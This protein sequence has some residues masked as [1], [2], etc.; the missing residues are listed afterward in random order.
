MLWLSMLAIAA[1][2]CSA[3]L[4]SAS[5][6][7]ADY[8]RRIAIDKAM[9]QG[10]GLQLPAKSIRQNRIGVSTVF[11][12][13][14]NL[15]LL[16]GELWQSVV[17][18]RMPLKDVP[19]EGIQRVVPLGLYLVSLGGLVRSPKVRWHECQWLM[20]NA[21]PLPT[22]LLMMEGEDNEQV[23]WYQ[24]W[25]GQKIRTVRPPSRE[26]GI[27]LAS[28]NRTDEV[29]ASSPAL[30]PDVSDKFFGDLPSLVEKVPALISHR[31]GALPVHLLLVLGFLAFLAYLPAAM[32]QIYKRLF[33]PQIN[34][35][36]VHGGNF[37]E[38]DKGKVNYWIVPDEGQDQVVLRLTAD[39]STASSFYVC[40]GDRCSEPLRRKATMRLN[41]QQLTM[42]LSRENFGTRS[43][44]K[45]RGFF[46]RTVYV[47]VVDVPKV[48]ITLGTVSKNAVVS[49]QPSAFRG[50]FASERF[51]GA[52]EAVSFDFTADRRF[53]DF[54]LRTSILSTRSSPRRGDPGCKAS[55]ADQITCKIS[56][57]QQWC[58]KACDLSA[59]LSMKFGTE[60]LEKPLRL[61]LEVR[62]SELFHLQEVVDLQ[63]KLDA[64]PE[65][66][67]L[68]RARNSLLRETYDFY[69]RH[70]KRRDLE[71]T[72]I[73]LT[74]LTGAGKSSA[75]RFLTM[76]ESCRYSN[77]WSSHTKN[78][79]EICGHAFGDE[80]QPR[81]NVFDIPGFGDTEGPAVDER[82][83]SETINYLADTEGLDA[84]FWVVNGAIRRKL[85]IRRYMLQ[86]YRKAF[87]SQFLGKL[88]VIV[89]FVP[90]M[91]YAAQEQLMS[92][93]IEEFR[94]FLLAEEQEFMQDAWKMVA[95]R[96]MGLISRSL[97]VRIVDMNPM[98]LEEKLPVPLSAPM[99]HRL[100]PYST[101]MN[102]VE[103]LDAVHAVADIRKSSGKRLVVNA[104][105]P[106]RGYG[107]VDKSRTSS[108]TQAVQDGPLLTVKLEGEFLGLG[109]SLLAQ[110]AR[111]ACGHAPADSDSVVILNQ[112]ASETSIF[113]VLL[114]YRVSAWPG[115][116]LCFREAPG[117]PEGRADVLRHCQEAGVLKLERSAW[118]D[119]EENEE[120]GLI[121]TLNEAK[122]TINAVVFAAGNLHHEYLATAGDDGNLRVYEKLFIQDY[123]RYSQRAE[124]SE[125]AGIVSL[126]V[127]PEAKNLAV[128]T[129]D[130]KILVYRRLHRNLELRA[131]R[132]STFVTGVAWCG[133]T[134]AAGSR[135]GRLDIMKLE[136]VDGKYR[137]TT[138]TSHSGITQVTSLA[139]FETGIATASTDLHVRLYS[140][141]RRPSS[142]DTIVPHVK[143]VALSAKYMASGSAD[144][145]VWLFQRN[146]YNQKSR[147]DA[148][149]AVLSVAFSDER[150]A[151][152]S[153]NGKVYVYKVTHGRDLKLMSVLSHSLQPIRAVSWSRE[154]VLAVGGNDTKVRLY[155]LK[156]ETVEGTVG[157]SPQVAYWGRCDVAYED[158][159]VMEI[160]AFMSRHMKK[161]KVRMIG[162]RCKLDAASYGSFA[163]ASTASSAWQ[164]AF[165]LP[166]LLRRLGI[167]VDLLHSKCAALA[168]GRR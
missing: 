75:C 146:S 80:L 153:A 94:A 58:S 115:V 69:R 88:H 52:L 120:Y 118:P 132:K 37:F 151:A 117:E 4:A 42:E 17:F 93:W 39:T 159:D 100:P 97:K 72:N 164:R 102:L 24:A 165:G 141:P 116:R 29:S 65:V 10:F 76:N 131:V 96:A 1:F 130:G 5:F 152:G 57:F 124:I 114:P 150:L 15:A 154:G 14:V 119:N 167:Q 16:L 140:H 66:A 45:L 106:I 127:S 51:L 148:Q 87:G 104:E 85:G 19:L 168:A 34:N 99:V 54:E 129:A 143:A 11:L 144:G 50:K 133:D 84:I 136:E 25:I 22:Y 70:Q 113:G 161:K 149:E 147:N 12:A 60:R 79:S 145:R 41:S 155:A 90:W 78:V 40:P 3:V 73:L 6:M 61:M 110:S 89:N 86:Q 98:Y 92:K 137:L 135:T 32:L 166:H 71:Q 38:E 126:A 53:F 63:R 28:R 9:S 2:T 23:Q 8:L 55:S 49:G 62:N 162:Q 74:G 122:G 13:F 101:P 47:A 68:R 43:S 128:S 46:T 30:E 33:M 105:C 125:K 27:E 91:P 109:D 121:Q 142:L 111:F 107:E 160:Y 59:E 31:R 158:Y 103:L 44:F 81:L 157:S 134:L 156:K 64:T 35:F 108:D 36:E 163:A 67:S 56:D 48:Q 83:F 123:A 7:L 20:R 138:M 112:S 18:Q 77:S 26:E 139:C 95:D 82:Q 21:R